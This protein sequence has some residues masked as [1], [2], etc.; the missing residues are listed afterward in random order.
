[1]S[2]VIGLQAKRDAVWRALQELQALIR[3]GRFR[4]PA[5]KAAERRYLALAG[6]LAELDAQLR[7]EVTLWPLR[8]GC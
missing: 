8:I 3:R 7:Q 1:M 2:H 5:L 6:D 4:G